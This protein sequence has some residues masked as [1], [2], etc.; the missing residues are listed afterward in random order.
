MFPALEVELLAADLSLVEAARVRAEA[1]PVVVAVA[2]VRWWMVP[3]PVF[4]EAA[5]P[6]V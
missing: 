6:V 4:E 1:Q 2:V 3:L 5:V